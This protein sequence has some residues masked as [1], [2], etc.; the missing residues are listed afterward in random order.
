[1]IRKNWECGAEDVMCVC[2]GNCACVCVCGP[3]CPQTY[4]RAYAN[5]WRSAGA[6]TNRHAALKD[7]RG[8]GCMAD[9]VGRLFQMSR[10]MQ[11]L[12]KITETPAHYDNDMP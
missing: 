9:M 6:D 1:M 11:G 4:V 8:R 2:V 3:E 12:Y 10:C 7:T 5:I